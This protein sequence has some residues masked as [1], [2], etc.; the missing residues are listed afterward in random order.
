MFLT[1]DSGHEKTRDCLWSPHYTQHRVPWRASGR[2]SGN[3]YQKNDR[4]SDFM[5]CLHVIVSKSGLARKLLPSIVNVRSFFASLCL[6]GVGGDSK[7]RLSFCTWELKHE[8]STGILNS[9]FWNS[10]YFVMSIEGRPKTLLLN[11]WPIR[12][13]LICDKHTL[14]TCTCYTCMLTH[15]FPAPQCFPEK[16]VTLTFALTFL[17]V[18]EFLL[19]FGTRTF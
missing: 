6:A 10:W 16:P 15:T 8:T 5:S 11:H 13:F 4:K 14:T 18:Y 12:P 9:S 3:T 19:E 7:C 2:L 1:A 17:Q